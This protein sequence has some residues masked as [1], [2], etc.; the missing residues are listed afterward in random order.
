MEKPDSLE[1]PEPS[2][3]KTKVQRDGKAGL[4]L[5]RKAS[6]GRQ[7]QLWREESESEDLL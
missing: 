7:K 5:P 2:A 6:M 1:N 3:V 4:D